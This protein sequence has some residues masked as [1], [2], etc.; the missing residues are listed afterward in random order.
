MVDKTFEAYRGARISG[1][2]G[3]VKYP[4]VIVLASSDTIGR[5]I[6]SVPMPRNF[7]WASA[8]VVLLI[9]PIVSRNFENRVASGLCLIQTPLETVVRLLCGDGLRM[10][11]AI[12]H[13]HQENREHENL[14]V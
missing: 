2:V 11:H 7:E 3:A 14:D 5:K 13:R 8:N 1:T 9:I 6:K 4:K 10:Q 12:K